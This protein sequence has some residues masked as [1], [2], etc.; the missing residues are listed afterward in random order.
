M[1]LLAD[2]HSPETGKYDRL[3][4]YVDYDGTDVSNTMLGEG[5]AGLYRDNDNIDRYDDHVTVASK[6]PRC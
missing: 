2:P 3:L 6:T 5:Y 1:I 4:A